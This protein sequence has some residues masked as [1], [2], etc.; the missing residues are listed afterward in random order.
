MGVTM[1]RQELEKIFKDLYQNSNAETREQ[2]FE[3]MLGAIPTTTLIC[4]HIDAKNAGVLD[5]SLESVV[6]S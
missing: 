5:G 4:I 2:L 1:K 3:E 6:R